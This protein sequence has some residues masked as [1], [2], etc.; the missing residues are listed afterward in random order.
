[1][2][3]IESDHKIHKRREIEKITLLEKRAWQSDTTNANVTLTELP[4]TLLHWLQQPAFC[5]YVD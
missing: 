3:N 2:K 5:A 1:M 4:L